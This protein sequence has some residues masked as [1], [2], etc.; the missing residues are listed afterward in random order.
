[1]APTM[2]YFN[3]RYQNNCAAIIF[4]AL[5]G[6]K[7][8]ACRH[9]KGKFK[10]WL[11]WRSW[12]KDQIWPWM[13]K[14]IIFAGG[15]QKCALCLKSSWIWQPENGLHVATLQLATKCLPITWTAKATWCPLWLTLRLAGQHMDFLGQHR[16]ETEPCQTDKGPSQADKVPLRP[17]EGH[18]KL[19]EGP[20]RPE[21]GPS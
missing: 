7:T 20:F 6:I 21:R 11:K 12:G 3:K 10:I 4:L 13:T 19:T 5:R 14:L 1:M 17:T 18:L 16:A 15:Q 2:L 8:Y 9:K